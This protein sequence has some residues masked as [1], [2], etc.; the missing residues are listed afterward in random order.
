MTIAA[1]VL[2]SFAAG[3]VAGGFFLIV[4]GIRREEKLHSLLHR[5]APGRSSLVARPFTGL[6]V[7]QQ[8]DPDAAP[9]RED[10]LV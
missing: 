5:W 1:I 8:I 9:D 10:T 3:G 6:W 7:R 4:H 2:F